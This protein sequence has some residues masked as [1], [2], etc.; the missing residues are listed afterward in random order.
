MLTVFADDLLA[1]PTAELEK[2]ASFV[3]VRVDRRTLKGAVQQQMP[4][5]RRA[6]GGLSELSGAQSQGTQGTAAGAVQGP[7]AQEENE[8]LLGQY[9]RGLKA[10]QLEMQSTADLSEW[11]CR[12]FHDFDPATTAALPIPPKALAA[13]C[14]APH[15]TCSVQFD[16]TEHERSQRSKK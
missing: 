12:S 8:S 11:P 2:M 15:V 16:R 9:Q 6:W 7:R 13:D 4:A 3:G 5:L 10:M 14:D 1:R